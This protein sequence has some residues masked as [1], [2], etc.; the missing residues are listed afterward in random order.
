MWLTLHA[1]R[2]LVTK[3]EIEIPGQYTTMN[4]AWMNFHVFFPGSEPISSMPYGMN[5]KD[6]Y[7]LHDRRANNNFD[8]KMKLVI[9]IFN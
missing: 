5:K 9:S 8:N 3:D 4:S 2:G 6:R 1:L 7:Y